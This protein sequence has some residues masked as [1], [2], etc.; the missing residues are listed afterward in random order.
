[1]HS[2]NLG[3]QYWSY[4]LVHATY[5]NNRLP[6]SHLEYKTPY[7]VYT[8]EVPN[9]KHFRVFGCRVYA[10]DSQKRKFKLDS[11]VNQGIYLG[12][13]ATLKNIYYRDE[14]TGIVKPTTYM[15]YDEAHM[16]LAREKVPPAA[17]ALQNLGYA[18]NN[19]T[20]KKVIFV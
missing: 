2:A 8:N 10:K 11:D 7:E 20:K 9:L 1:M 17:V 18:F 4:A 15:I 14:K 5:V 6:H 12:H 16:T 19:E 3:P 13:A